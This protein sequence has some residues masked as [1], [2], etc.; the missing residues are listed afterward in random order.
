MGITF[1][2][3]LHAIW[4]YQRD[5][6]ENTKNALPALR[7]PIGEDGV[8]LHIEHIEGKLDDQSRRIKR[9]EEKLAGTGT[10]VM[11]FLGAIVCLYFMLAGKYDW[12]GRWTESLGMLAMFTSLGILGLVKVF[13]G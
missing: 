7:S 10:I 3:L 2:I 11:A 1:F 6:E 8:R 9:I 13:R 4:A 5:P 12:P